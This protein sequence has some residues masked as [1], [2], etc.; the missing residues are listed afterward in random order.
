[1]NFNVPYLLYTSEDDSAALCKTV[2]GCAQEWKS[3]GNTVSK[4]QWTIS[5]PYPKLCFTSVVGSISGVLESLEELCACLSYERASRGVQSF[6]AG[7]SE[8]NWRVG[9][10]FT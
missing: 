2:A 9:R 5:K 8:Q 3:N 10:L 1:M 4:L 6:A 7:L